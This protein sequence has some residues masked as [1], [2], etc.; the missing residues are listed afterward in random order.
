M[1]PPTRPIPTMKMNPIMKSMCTPVQSLCLAAVTALALHTSAGAAVVLAVDFGGGN[2]NVQ[3][4]FQGFNNPAE[5]G[6]SATQS[7]S[8]ITVTIDGGTN[9]SG[10]GSAG[11]L[12]SRDRA[13]APRIQETTLTSPF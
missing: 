13:H 6:I 11:Y 3:S 12:N 8:G 2:G 9:T 4:G 7:Y 1:N 10:V 5:G